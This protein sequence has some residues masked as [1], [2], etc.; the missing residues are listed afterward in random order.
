MLTDGRTAAAAM[1]AGRE[2][3]GRGW[4]TSHTRVATE[5]KVLGL[6][7]CDAGTW[8]AHTGGRAPAPVRTHDGR[9]PQA[10]RRGPQHG[11]AG[12]GRGQAHTLGASTQ[13]RR[14]H[15]GEDLP[16]R[17]WHLAPRAC[18]CPTGLCRVAGVLHLVWL[19]RGR[20]VARV[21][22]RPRSE[23][24]RTPAVACACVAALLYATCARSPTQ[25][26]T[27]RAS[28]LERDVGCR[29]CCACTGVGVGVAVRRRRRARPLRTKRVGQGRRCTRP[30]TGTAPLQ[31]THGDCRCVAA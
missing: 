26:R 6:R 2:G 7:P 3:T 20:C 4:G 10:A 29:V 23:H 13:Q 14:K 28:H 22:G 15:A 9:G 11:A 17:W 19:P 5:C 27:C 30:G 12:P 8:A 31:R 25:V 18:R 16:C 24:A 1:G 21:Q